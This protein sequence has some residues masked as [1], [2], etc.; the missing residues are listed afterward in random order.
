MSSALHHP[1]TVDTC[2]AWQERQESRHE[3][4]K[5]G[6]TDGVAAAL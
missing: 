1:T 4:V 6:G 5:A 2:L 3:E